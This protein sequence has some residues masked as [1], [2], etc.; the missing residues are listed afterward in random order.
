M[1]IRSFLFALAF[2]LAGSVFS[3]E[4]P[5]ER[6]N[7]LIGKW[8]GTGEGF[9]SS[10]SIVKSEFNWIMNNNFIEVI[11]RSEFKPT[12]QKPEGEIHEDFGIISYNK[13]SKVIIYRQYHTEGFYNEYILADSL[14]N[15]NILVFDTE[16]IENFVPGG[17]ARE[18]IIIKSNSEIETRFDVGFPGK[19]MTCMGKNKLIK[20]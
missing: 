13:A 5:L 19:E 3:Q 15:E 11:N 17:R 9:G 4:N 10:T 20:K 2:L 7:N 14:S 12:L 6:F 8:E 18:T 1:K 16:K